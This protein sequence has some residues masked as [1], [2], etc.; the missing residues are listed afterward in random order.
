MIIQRLTQITHS[1]LDE[2]Q[3]LIRQLDP[4]PRT[5]S[6]SDVSSMLA[7]GELFFFVVRDDA[8][9]NMPIIGMASII[10]YQIPTCK[11]GYIEDVVVDQNYRGLGLGRQLTQ[12]CIDTARENNAKYIDLTSNPSRVAANELYKKMGFERRET[13]VYRMK[14]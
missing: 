12:K 6:L 2:I 4:D 3:S 13:N 5:I 1:D 8:K 14:L 11:K 7:Q 9:I 10:I